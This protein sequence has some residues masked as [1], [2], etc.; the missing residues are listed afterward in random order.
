MDHISKSTLP[1]RCLINNK[2]ANNRSFIGIPKASCCVKGSLNSI[3]FLLESCRQS[4][5]CGL[6]FFG[7]FQFEIMSHVSLYVSKLIKDHALRVKQDALEQAAKAD[8]LLAMLS[9][10]RN[11]QLKSASSSSSAQ[12]ASPAASISTRTSEPSVQP[13]Q[14]KQRGGFIARQSVEET[15]GIFGTVNISFM[16]LGS[17][18]PPPGCACAPPAPPCG[19]G[20][21]YAPPAPPSGSGWVYGWF[22]GRPG[23]SW[24]PLAPPGSSWLSSLRPLAPPG[25]P[26]LLLDPPGF[27][28]L[29]LAPAGSP[30]L[31]VP[32]PPGFSWLLLAPPGSP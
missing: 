8:Q 14:K 13:G 4:Q 32:A 18:P 31:L 16:L 3:A 25:S 21:G 10:R 28:W 27:P 30:W 15:L 24:L 29:L 7:G 20:W 12:P 19:S 1:C 6:Y 9:P 22:G 23:S 26:W 2:R 17:C 11:P 5:P